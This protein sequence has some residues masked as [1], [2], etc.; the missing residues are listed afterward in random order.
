MPKKVVDK[1]FKMILEAYMA[2]PQI[3]LVHP[4]PTLIADELGYSRTMINSYLAGDSEMRDETKLMAHANRKDWVGQLARDLLEVIHDN[5][6]TQ[7]KQK[8]V[9]SFTGEIGDDYFNRRTGRHKTKNRLLYVSLDE[10]MFAVFPSIGVPYIVEMSDFKVVGE[11]DH[12]SI[13]KEDEDWCDRHGVPYKNAKVFGTVMELII[14]EEQKR[15]SRSN[16]RQRKH[17][18]VSTE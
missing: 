4:S 17:P 15:T 1:R 12:W 6:N 5:K 8:V 13:T 2:T 10:N 7:P 18:S 3:M 9:S 16:R 11:R 14:D